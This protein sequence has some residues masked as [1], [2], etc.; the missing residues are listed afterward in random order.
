M[1]PVRFSQLKNMARS[2][3]H[4]IGSVTEETAAIERGG[5]LHSIV[6]GGA[7]VMFYPGAVRRGKEWDAFQAANDGA[8]ILTRSE[9]DK[10][11]PMADSV[12]R[13][14]NAMMVLKG[15][16][17]VEVDWSLLGRACQSHVDC[18]GIN[19]EWVTELKST[20]DASPAR[21]MW[22]SLRMGYN[23]Q[24]AF[25]D[26]A[27]RASKLGK[28]NA[29]YVVAVES[30]P[31]FVV[32]VM[33]LTDKALDQGRRAFRLWFERLLACEAADQWPGY[34]DAIEDLDVPEE[35]VELVF[36]DSGDAEVAA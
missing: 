19:G 1:K 7:Q 16:H 29:H 22:Q 13:N 20:R 30:A 5:A 18:V 15:Q 2:P 4:Y 33:R 23:A 25:Y 32:T 26:Q 10:V 24:L 17:E 11:M 8:M 35:D 36:P 27:V 6:L 3:A 31:P 21:F 12:R 14:A 34:C 28:P 9:Y